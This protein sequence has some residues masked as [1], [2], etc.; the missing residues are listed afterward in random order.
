[1][2]N[3]AASLNGFLASFGM[4]TTPLAALAG[5]GLAAAPD[6]LRVRVN[7]WARVLR[8]L[9]AALMVARALLP[10]APHGH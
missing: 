8:I 5:A 7:R 3:L 6:R 1:M 4:G 9:V 10:A 2:A